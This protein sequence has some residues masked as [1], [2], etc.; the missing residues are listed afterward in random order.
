MTHEKKI[1]Y[2]R[3]AASLCH[4]GFDLKQLDMLVSLYELIVKKEGETNM[5]DIV[6]V[7]KEVN[8]RDLERLAEAK[9]KDDGSSR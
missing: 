7:E 1:I 8:D 2:M 5:M 4:F 3:Q 6:T 9:N